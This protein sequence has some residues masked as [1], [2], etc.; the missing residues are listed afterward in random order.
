[1]PKFGKITYI[2]QPQREKHSACN[3]KQLH[4]IKIRSKSD[5][6]KSA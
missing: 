4:Q 1:M 5:Q 2:D 3:G 6:K